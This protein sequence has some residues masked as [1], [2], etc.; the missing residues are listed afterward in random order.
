[1]VHPVDMAD[2]VNREKRILSQLL[3]GW[4]CFFSQGT[5]RGGTVGTTVDH[6]DIRGLVTA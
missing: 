6:A 5:G 4:C 1:M 3:W 2:R